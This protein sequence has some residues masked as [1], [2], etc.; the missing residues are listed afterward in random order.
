[1]GN[2][3][4]LRFLFYASESQN[5]GQKAVT[6]ELFEE[7]SAIVQAGEEFL[8]AI[9]REP[10]IPMDALS[11][12]RVKL[13][14][15]VRRHRLT[16]EEFIF[17]PLIREGGFGKLPHLEPFVQDLMREKARYSEHIRK[18]TPPAIQADW[19]GYVLAVE[20]LLRN[21][22]RVIHA[23]ESGLYQLVLGLRATQRQESATRRH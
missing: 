15:L 17:G 20:D 16:E 19:N 5:R 18:W 4:T 11:R 3:F 6:V 8:A 1:M 22:K 23:E 9:K 12:M 7:H 21:L 13:S 10:R 14:A 2:L